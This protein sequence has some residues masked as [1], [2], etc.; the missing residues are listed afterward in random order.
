MTCIEA[1]TVAEV[2]CNCAAM[3][4]QTDHLYRADEDILTYTVLDEA[5]EAAAGVVRGLATP[6][7]STDFYCSLCCKT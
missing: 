4:D 3:D 2:S 5:V 7:P 1:Q 6:D